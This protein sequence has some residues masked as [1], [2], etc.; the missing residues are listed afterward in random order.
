LARFVALHPSNLAQKSEIVVEH[1]RSFTRHQIGGRAKAMV[2]TR[3]RL[4]AVRYQQAI[5]KYIAEK[6]YTDLRALVAF[7]GTVQDPDLPGVSYTEPSMNRARDGRSIPESV[8]EALGLA[9]ECAR[10]SLI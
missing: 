2:V 8:A 7:S 4:H 6:R 1:F 9:D 5:E 10:R 3:S